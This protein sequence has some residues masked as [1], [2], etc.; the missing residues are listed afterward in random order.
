ME[1][2]NFL[3]RFYP[4][5]TIRKHRQLCG[6]SQRELARKLGVEP[7]TVCSWEFGCRMAT[8]DR[9]L[10]LS[11]LLSTFPT[12]LYYCFW[13]NITTGSVVCTNELPSGSICGLSVGTRTI[14][15]A[16]VHEGRLIQWRL[17]T[18]KDTW[19]KQKR[20]RIAKRLAVLLTRY[21]VNLIGVRES[22]FASAMSPRYAQ[23]VL[24]IK[25]FAVKNSVPFHKVSLGKFKDYWSEYSGANLRNAL[26]QISNK[27]PE[28]P[29]LKDSTH[30][31]SCKIYEA[32]GI[33]KMLDRG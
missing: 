22:T 11:K 17:F 2:S 9:L 18:F 23:V 4:F 21:R 14:G 25:R 24:D 7:T 26:L 28:L 19:S 8:G 6:L 31:D 5:N 12:E 27:Y 33:A 16:I 10:L 20:M 30:K 32:V 3:K 13:G 1:S 15:F 29:E